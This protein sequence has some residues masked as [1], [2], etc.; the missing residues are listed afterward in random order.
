[1]I[2]GQGR[3]SLSHLLHS[4]GG[5]DTSYSITG[6][7]T[8]ECRNLQLLD[9]NLHWPL[10]RRRK[11]GKVSRH[12]FGSFLLRLA[13]AWELRDI[14]IRSV[15]DGGARIASSIEGKIGEEQRY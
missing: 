5:A 15:R 7:M 3:Y 9:P 8:S 6:W 12:H 4:C 14:A 2:S 11:Q 10:R 13:Q 1:M